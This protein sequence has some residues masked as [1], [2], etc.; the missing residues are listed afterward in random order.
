[1]CSPD[2]N[3]SVISESNRHLFI[4]KNSYSTAGGLRK[5]T[6]PQMLIGQQRLIALD[7]TGGEI[8]GIHVENESVLVLTESSVLCLQLADEE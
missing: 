7:G 1:M 2:M 3:L 4:Y 6:G 5:R 8:L